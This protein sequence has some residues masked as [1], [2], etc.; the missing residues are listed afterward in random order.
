MKL[1]LHACCGPCS[2]ASVETLRA[3]GIEPTLFWFNPNIHPY[4]EYKSRLESL[5]TFADLQNLSLIEQGDYGLRG[6]V[7]AVASDI[8]HRCVVCYELRMMETAKYASEN[9]FTHFTSTLFISPYQNHELMSQVAI[10]A[11]E[12]YGVTFLPRDFRPVFREGQKKARDMGLY[13]QKYCGCIFSEEDRYRK[14]PK[15]EA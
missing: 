5:R 12:R 2:V 6:F 13:M 9:G 3:E 15:K 10:K 14:K 7:G 4:L 11:G 1:L 8:D